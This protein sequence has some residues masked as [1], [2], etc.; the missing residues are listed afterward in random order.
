M[1][2]KKY[3]VLVTGIG[4]II[5][6]GVIKSLRNSNIDVDI[7]GMDIYSDAVGQYWCDNFVQ[8]KYA[9]DP[10]YISF[11]INIIKKYNIDIVFFG[12]EQEI[13]RVNSCR[14]E[15]GEYFNKFVINREH[16]LELAK[17]KWK[18]YQYLI[19]NDMEDI[20]IPSKILGT[21]NDIKEEFGERFMLKPRCSYASKGIEIVENE[22][23]FDF[24]KNRMK[25]NFMAQ[26]LIGDKEHEYTVG[27]F[28]LGDGTYS[29]LI[30]MRR[31]LSQEGA[32]AKAEVVVSSKLELVVKKLVFGLKPIGPTNFQFRYENGNYYLLE[33]NPR[34]SSSTSIR[35]A[36]GYNEAVSSIEFF[37]QHK[38]NKCKIKQGRA[39]RYID[40]VIDII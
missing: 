6:Y 40:E 22:A 19:E 25:E 4:A 27:V 38:I 35:A 15:L 3:N 17:D 13:Y 5:G 16:L 28:G 10:E 30:A 34:I 29:S 31:V 23:E 8:A 7:T 14:D 12:T 1:K 33:V 24:F 18:T 2:N 36:F 39:L 26:R 37:I 32:T 11:L 9:V 21:Y 20:A